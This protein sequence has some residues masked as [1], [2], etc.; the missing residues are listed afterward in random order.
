M[1]ELTLV[2]LAILIFCLTFYIVATQVRTYRKLKQIEG[3]RRVLL[4]SFKLQHCT[5]TSHELLI[6]IYRL[7]LLI[8]VNYV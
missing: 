1:E 3:A 2:L 4:V 5:S 8:H 6:D 7:R